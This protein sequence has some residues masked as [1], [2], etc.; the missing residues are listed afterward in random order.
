MAGLYNEILVGR[1]NRALQKLLDMKGGAP[2]PQLS[3]DIQPVF[4]FPWGAGERYLFSEESFAMGHLIA[5]SVAN[6]SVQNMRNPTLS[7]V[8][9]VFL[10]L[11][12]MVDAADGAL[13]VSLGS[14]TT[15][16]ANSA[17]AQR[18]DS[19]GRPTPS[20]LATND[21]AAASL[22][23]IGFMALEANVQR[24]FIS[25]SLQGIPLLPGNALRIRTSVTN[26]ALRVSYIWTE[27]PLQPSEE[28]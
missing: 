28:T 11:T 20:I 8:I 6:P 4:Q 18:L 9:A 17:P 14:S 16:L 15:D 27:R 5:A 10:K 2:A 1:F 22:T 25:G 23:R 3:S 7:G 24:D 12:V 26:V 21:N 13:V 19:R